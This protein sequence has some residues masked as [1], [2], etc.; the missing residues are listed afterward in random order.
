MPYRDESLI[1]IEIGS[2]ETRAIF[3][4]SE[5]L[6]PPKFRT[7]T[8]VAMRPDSEEWICGNDLSAAL[9]AGESLQVME[10]L[11]NGHIKDWSALTAFFKYVIF[12]L[13][14]EVAG[15]RVAEYPVILMA[16]PQWSPQ[17]REKITQLFLRNFL[18]PAFMI[19]DMAF[20]S[21]YAC[22]AVTG[23][24]VDVGYQ[25]T[26]VTTI[27]D[28]RTPPSGHRSVPCGGFHM[29]ESLL[30]MLRRNPPLEQQ[31]QTPMSVD[32][33][34]F[35]LAESIK[36][37]TICEILPGEF[38]SNEMAFQTEEPVG[39]AEEGVLDIAAV[40]A[41]G[42]TREYLARIQAGKDGNAGAQQDVVPNAQLT[43]NTTVVKDK[44]IVV[45]S[46][47]FKVAD[48]LLEDG[49]LL[50][51][52]YDS[53]ANATIEPSRRH[54]L[55]ENIVLVGGG[56][57]VKGFRDKMLQNLQ[58]RYA[59]KL[60]QASADPYAPPLYNAYPT[61]IRIIKI[62]I[63]FPEWNGKSEDE[64]KKGINEEATFLGGCIVA[65]I[66]FSSS[67]TG[68][69]RLYSTMADYSESGPVVGVS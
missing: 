30:A 46:D 50:D 19:A 11:V 9:A 28:S 32:D 10:P 31:N 64:V 29:T 52:V 3:G 62:P 54:E 38:G 18:R 40:V 25:Q 60:T 56:A 55:W 6:T 17:D 66:A 69:A 58:L 12:S 13:N 51:A 26:N 57:R 45:G 65:H 34:D 14:G 27:I 7:R 4:L 39:E 37:S 21:L 48:V 42:K 8:H 23:I 53:I 1:C 5:S 35:A 68:P 43:H 33:L 61:T 67:E 47:R 59:S 44:T 24:V 16:P 36:C 2:F 22:N 49:I 41:S 15:S 20:A 63:H